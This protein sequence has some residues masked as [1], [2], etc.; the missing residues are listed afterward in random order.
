MYCM[1][2]YRMLLVSINE[3]DIPLRILSTICLKSYGILPNGTIHY[4]KWYVYVHSCKFVVTCDSLSAC[5]VE[6]DQITKLPGVSLDTTLLFETSSTD[7]TS[8]YTGVNLLCSAVVFWAFWFL[9]S[10]T[11]KPVKVTAVSGIHDKT[12]QWVM[13]TRHVCKNLE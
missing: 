10:Q 3:F 12:S 13:C 9:W 2:W 5:I 8:L 11:I 4:R 1:R 6:S 7:A